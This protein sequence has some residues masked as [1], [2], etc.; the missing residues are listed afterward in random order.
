M[1]AAYIT[2]KQFLRLQMT[3]SFYNKQ[4][5]EKI[6]YPAAIYLFRSWLHEK[7]WFAFGSSKCS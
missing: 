7:N 5:T 2:A 3:S 4:G 6:V 1:I